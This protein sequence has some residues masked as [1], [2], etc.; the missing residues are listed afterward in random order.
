MEMSSLFLQDSGKYIKSEI[1]TFCWKFSHFAEGLFSIHFAF[2]FFLSIL[3]FTGS[4][5]STN[6]L[7]AH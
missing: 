6:N 7:P 2:H 1:F 4:F 5:S 3:S